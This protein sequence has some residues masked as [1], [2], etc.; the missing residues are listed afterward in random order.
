MQALFI[1]KDLQFSS[2]MIMV[3]TLACMWFT[4]SSQQLRV[5]DAETRTPLMS[6]HLRSAG[7]VLTTAEN[8]KVDLAG[9]TGT[10]NISHTGYLT[11]VAEPGDTV[12]LLKPSGLQLLNTITI[13][14]SRTERLALET[15][16]SVS[17]LDQTTIHAGTPRTVPEALQQETGIW[18]QK[19]NHGGGS[20]IIRGMMGNQVLLMV[21][22]IRMNNTTY[23]FGPNQYLSTLDPYLLDRLEVVRGGSSVLYGSDAMGGV[24]QS[25]SRDP[26]FVNSKQFT[27]TEGQVTG[28]WMSAGME[29]SGSL[30]IDAG[31][32][33]FAISATGS[34]FHFGD[35]LA[36]GSLGRLS[37]TGYRQHSG[38]IRAKAKLTDNS[39]L[40]FAHQEMVQRDVPRYDQVLQGGYQ[41]YDFDPQS[42][43]LD[44]LRL[45]H[46]HSLAMARRITLTVFNSGTMEGLIT[47]KSNSGTQKDQNDKVATNGFT[48]EV[49]SQPERRWT[50]RSGAEFYH[51]RVQSTAYTTDLT[52]G[53]RTMVRGAY[54][55]GSTSTSAS[56]YTSH[57]LDLQRFSLSGGLRYTRVALSIRDGRFGDQ[58]INPDALVGS[59]SAGWK[60]SQPLRLYGSL[61]SGFRAPNV[62]DLSKFGTVESGVFEIPATGLK[63]EHSLSEEIG[64]KFLKKMISFSAAWYRTSVTDL[65][66]R[67]P[68]LYE[69]TPTFE[70]RNVYQ[71][72]NTGQARYTGLEA[73]AE[74]TLTGH[75]TLKGQ[76]TWTYGENLT[77]KEPA[78]RIPPLFG[79]V[80]LRYLAGNFSLMITGN[81]A[82]QQDRLAPGDRADARI[83][84]RL[85]DGVMPGWTTIDLSA[86]WSKG[87]WSLNLNIRNMGNVAYRVYGSGVDGYGR[88]AV[89]RLAYRF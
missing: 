87:P 1:I 81:V 10:L 89:L 51:D 55:D 62:D 73:E 50:I 69:G 8:G 7:M 27:I 88:H 14:A 65:V 12:I 67:I 26:R 29:T 6:A 72:A 42:R 49:E 20:P 76:A 84:L 48:A 79:K 24:V 53:T 60:I 9:T 13:T 15:D 11:A 19:T 59:V 25:F 4:T 77:K 54:A 66:D 58:R 3:M 31:N 83:A 61:H 2:R 41:R 22:G 32:N 78:R 30:R 45:D 80:A 56:L 21:D 40:T 63:P 17:I 75:L 16:R 36:G 68:A 70:G 46:Q 64:I 85:Q 5:L 37:P 28:G 35:L 74:W 82:G 39:Q 43:R 34:L 47:R 23:R 86:G 18:V 44:Y 57:Q 38:T 33:R 71:K 52:N